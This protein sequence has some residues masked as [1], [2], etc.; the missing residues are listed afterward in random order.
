[1]IAYTVGAHLMCYHSMT[2]LHNYQKTVF[3]MSCRL[4]PAQYSLNSAESWPK[5]T[6]IHSFLCHVYSKCRC[7]FVLHRCICQCYRCIPFIFHV[8]FL[9]FHSF[10]LQVH[11]Q[12]CTFSYYSC[13]FESYRCTFSCYMCTCSC[14]RCTFACYSCTF[15][16]YRCNFSFYRCTFSCSPLA[17]PQ[18]SAVRSTT[19]PS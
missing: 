6:I 4:S 8:H 19:S 18:T 3:L 11:F 16:C 5:T 1:M 15:S 2:Y 17:T 14:Y 7:S 12:I 9:K 10:L 13:N